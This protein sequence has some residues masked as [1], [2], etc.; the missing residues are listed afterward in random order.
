MFYKQFKLKIQIQLKILVILY[1][2]VLQTHLS[3]TKSSFS[4]GFFAA[5]AKFIYFLIFLECFVAKG[6]KYRK[7]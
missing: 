6:L 3:G 4:Y 7:M 5:N 1:S 2:E